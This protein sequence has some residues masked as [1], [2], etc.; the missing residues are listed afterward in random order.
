MSSNCGSCLFQFD[1]NTDDKGDSNVFCLVKGLWLNENKTCPH[2]AEYAEIEQDVRSR[3]ALEIRQEEAENRR[4]K[5]I[6]RSNLKFAIAIFVVSFFLF[7]A[8]VKLFDKY[9]F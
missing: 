7:W 3:I 1:R 4:L 8:T 6:V 5:K 2:F 9:L